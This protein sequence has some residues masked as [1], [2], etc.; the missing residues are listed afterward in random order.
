MACFE[1]FRTNKYT[2]RVSAI[3]RQI[4]RGPHPF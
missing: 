1:G 4:L 2:K 3:D